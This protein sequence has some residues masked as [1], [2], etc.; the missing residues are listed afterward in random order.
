MRKPALPV[1]ALLLLAVCLALVAACDS[2]SSKAERLR[3]GLSDWPG[4]APF[5]AAGKLDL[6]KPAEVEIKGFS[7]NFDRNRAFSQG[8]L[9]VLA[10]P[11]FDALR[12]AD[13]GGSL[14]IILFFDY[15]SGGDGIVARK[16]IARVAELKGKRVG[17]ELGAITHFVLLAAL[18]QAG[19]AEGDM[20]VVNLSVPEA[21]E[22]FEK[23]K[24]DAATLW[25]PHLSRL[26]SAPGAH[27]LFTSKEIPGLVTD[28]LVAQKE[29][30][31]ARPDDIAS[32]V[33]GWER[34]LSSYRERPAELEAIMAK[35]MN[36]PV[37]GLRE[38][39][40]GLSLLDLAKNRALYDPKTEGP[41]AWSSYETTVQF[42]KKH[43]LLK[44]AAIDPKEILDARFVER[45]LSNLG[46]SSK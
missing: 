5:Y 32:I 31:E 2:K 29:V 27:K 23:G 22:A 10:T 17:A 39:L 25:D 4:H 42:M 6:F 33:R 24:L 8:R 34:A 30:A 3:L 45:A 15:S 13:D 14:K 7:S 41:S 1:A 46:S 44:R 40:T 11:L 9:D 20:T 12:I 38:D 43:N 18:S 16:E 19:L 21:A 37:E 26:A 35:E 28:V 36:R